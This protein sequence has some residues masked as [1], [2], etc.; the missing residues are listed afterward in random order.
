MSEKLFLRVVE[1][2]VSGLVISVQQVVQHGVHDAFHVRLVYIQ[3]QLRLTQELFHV[4]VCPDPRPGVPGSPPR[5]LSSAVSVDSGATTV[6][7]WEGQGWAEDGYPV[8]SP[9]SGLENVSCR[10]W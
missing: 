6:A 3:H 7:K 10:F 5:S 2:R 1:R 8:T 4:Q 9:L